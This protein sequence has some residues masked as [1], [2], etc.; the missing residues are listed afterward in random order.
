MDKFIQDI[1][2]QAGEAV[3]KLFGKVGV[4]YSKENPLDVVTKADLKANQM[5][6]DRIQKRYPKHG[7][8]S[9]E[10][11]SINPG[12]EYCWIIDPIDG[13]LNFATHI[14]V[15]GVMV[16]LARRGVVELA[17]IASPCQDELFF[18]QAGHGTFNNGKRVTCAVAT[19]LA[20]GVGCVP[21]RLRPRHKK[22]FQYLF[23]AFEKNHFWLSMMGSCAITATS[24]AAGRKHWLISDGGKIWDY[25][26]T[27]LILQ[28]AGCKVTN[29]S[30]E[31]WTLKDTVML[32]ANPV[33]HAKLLKM[34]KA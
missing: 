15:F 31:P 21:S 28:E 16:A 2:R 26:A 14:P 6:V 32:A 5:L 3:G 17:A 8:I 22:I 12:A 24:V 34:V 18:A 4:H 27:A 33:L 13:T 29:F 19:S 11:E 25:A 30:G 9:E 7:I 10:Q 20:D 23:K 1:T